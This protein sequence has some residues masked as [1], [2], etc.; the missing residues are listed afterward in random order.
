[1]TNH[2]HLLVRV[3]GTHLSDAQIAP[4][5]QALPLDLEHTEVFHAQG[6][7]LTYLRLYPRPTATEAQGVDSELWLAQGTL[8]A[9]LLP[10]ESVELAWLQASLYTPGASHRSKQPAPWHY[11]VETDV[12]AEAEADFN[13][14]YDTEHLPGLA[15]VEGV[16]LAQR[17]VSTEHH[18]RYH[19]SYDLLT[20]ETF[21]CPAW[22]KVRATPWSDRVRPEFRNPR[23]L[24]FQHVASYRAP[25]Q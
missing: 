13:Q 1:M 9:R 14:W 10:A 16:K 5:L 22:L 21:G 4:W 2:T 3:H 11:V 25:A 17:F 23:R 18:P 19:A 12:T 8:E 7:A 15:A 24:M 6:Q 20:Q